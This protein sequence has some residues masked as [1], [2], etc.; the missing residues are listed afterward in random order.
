MNGKNLSNPF[1][2]GGGGPH[3]E[4]YVQASFVAL[5]LTV[6]FAPCLACYPISKIQLQAKF[7]GYDTDDLIVFVENP[8]GEQKRKI[9]GH[10]V[11]ITL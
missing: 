10:S 4:A 9:L 11:M 3:F 6:G 1:S 7:A 2:T 8:D 5:M